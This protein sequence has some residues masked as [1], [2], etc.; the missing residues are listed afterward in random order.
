MRKSYIPKTYYKSPAKNSGKKA[1]N[2]F[3]AFLKLL[4]FVIIMGGISYI[5]YSPI[6]N[7]RSFNLNLEDGDLKQDILAKAESSVQDN[8][9]WWY[10]NKNIFLLRS[11]KLE[12]YLLKEFPNIKTIDIKRDIF[13][14][15]INLN[16]NFRTAI[17]RICE[18]ESCY[19]ISEEG[20]N[21]GLNTSDAET[22]V[23]IKGTGPKSAGENV[24]S[25]REI[26]WLKNILQEYN[27]IDSI[28]IS[29]IDIQQRSQESIISLFVYTD[30]G[31]Y[32]ILDLDTDIIYQAQVL[33]QVFISQIPLEK[34]SILEY[35]DLRIK[36]R[37]Y[38][39]FK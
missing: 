34:R 28:K 33:K 16:I 5:L 8:N 30:Q 35:I 23:I 3:I 27:K 13:S 20:V 36:D 25:N 1:K 12:K 18:N 2:L 26:N 22:L 14:Q 10:N 24:F 37:V 7:I 4:V 15:T 38:Y 17:F 11:D 32:M 6:L 21:M 39:K 19:D 31:Y 9:H 29:S